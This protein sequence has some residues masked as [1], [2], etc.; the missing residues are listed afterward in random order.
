[1][2]TEVET[3]YH[4]Y[5]VATGKYNG[6]LKTTEARLEAYLLTQ[7]GLSIGPAPTTY[8][9]YKDGVYVESWR[10]GTLGYLT[11]QLALREGTWTYFT[12]PFVP[13]VPTAW[14][15]NRDLDTERDPDGD[16]TYT[17]DDVINS[18]HDISSAFTGRNRPD[19]PNHF[20]KPTWNYRRLD[21]PEWSSGAHLAINTVRK[22][23]STDGDV[24]VYE[25]K[26]AHTPTDA[27]KPPNTAFWTVLKDW[28]D[29]GYDL[30]RGSTNSW[31]YTDTRNINPESFKLDFNFQANLAARH[32]FAIFAGCKVPNF[33]QTDN[34]IGGG[35]LLFVSVSQANILT[36]Q[37]KRGD[38]SYLMANGT[39]GWSVFNRA[40]V[41]GESVFDRKQLVIPT[42][43]HDV[44]AGGRSINVK[45]IH[46]EGKLILY[47]EGQKK[48]EFIYDDLY[49]PFRKALTKL[50]PTEGI[51]INPGDLVKTRGTFYGMVG[52]G[53]QL[54]NTP[55]HVAIQRMVWSKLDANDFLEG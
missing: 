37:V 23:T 52:G 51:P 45:I 48:G 25:A 54:G 5:Y 44:E 30:A 33:T 35:I 21:V 46:H 13:P 11:A 43:Q 40:Y 27:N 24:V 53:S 16:K 38:N 8:Y 4:T 22:V 19:T 36:V 55:A 15:L 1:M 34:G 39:N 47:T 3:R 7:P 6:S 32:G 9:L 20:F 2:P 28:N 12:T 29:H 17:L 10:R 31:L 50:T 26:V 18:A 42:I 49:Y 41:Q 14:E